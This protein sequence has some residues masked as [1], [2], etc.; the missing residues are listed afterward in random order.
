MTFADSDIAELRAL[1]AN[2]TPGPFERINGR[3]A[4]SHYGHS[5]GGLLFS[6][7]RDAE[8]WCAAVNALPALLDAATER[9]LLLMSPN[10]RLDGY[11]ELG[12]KCASLEGTIDALRAEIERMRGAATPTVVSCAV[13]GRKDCERSNDGYC[14][15]CHSEM[16]P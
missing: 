15:R 16:Y 8:F 6:N 1:M 12:A 5:F 9:D 4:P 14:G 13:R 10:A 11:R 2:S 3:V 7:V